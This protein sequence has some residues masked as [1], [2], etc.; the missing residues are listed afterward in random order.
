MAEK[1]Y[2]RS[3]TGMAPQINR[4]RDFFAYWTNPGDAKAARQRF[5]KYCVTLDSTAITVSKL[6]MAM[7]F[8]VSQIPALQ[9]VALP[10][11]VND[12]ITD[13]VDSALPDLEAVR[14][15]IERLIKLLPEM[16]T[17]LR[18]VD[19]KIFTFVENLQRAHDGKMEEFLA[20]H[21]ELKTLGERTQGE[22]LRVN[23]SPEAAIIHVQ[24]PSN[25]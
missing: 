12:S 7:L 1:H 18:D 14:E 6:M 4:Q 8:G 19:Q 15:P 3:A 5:L 24:V 21:T 2:K 20:M 10:T 17:A 9:S 23:F 22:Y 16:L 13:D 11:I 25:R